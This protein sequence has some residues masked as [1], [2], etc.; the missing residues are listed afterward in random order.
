[1]RGSSAS[2]IL[3]S[4]FQ[5]VHDWV[6]GMSEEKLTL[7]LHHQGESR[8]AVP[9]SLSLL[10]TNTPGGKTTVLDICIEGLVFNA[11]LAKLPYGE[12]ELVLMESVAGKRTRVSLFNA[13]TRLYKAYERE[14][15]RVFVEVNPL[16]CRLLSTPEQFLD[17]DWHDRTFEY[18]INS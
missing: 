6:K 16:A 14:L 10:E 11:V 15:H 5:W 4:V 9:M 1:M 2:P 17:P 18:W 8:F 3:D 13:T 7:F 12:C